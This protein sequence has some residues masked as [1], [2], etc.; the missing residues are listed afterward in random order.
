LDAL[1]PAF[2]AA[3]L[4]GIGDRPARLAA[5]IGTRG[6]F[7]ALIAGFV[8]GHATA[9]GIAVAGAVLIAPR[10]TPEAKSLMLAIALI[11]AGLGALWRRRPIAA[12]DEGSVFVSAATGS[13]LGGDATAFLAFAL[14]ARG[15][16]PVLAGIGALGGAMVLALVAATLARDWE[17][18]PLT[19]ISRIAGIVLCVTGLIVALGGLRLI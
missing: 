7:G 8:L 15:S 14:A 9:I 4:A 13:F 18:L 12:A 16:A 6:R 5:L 1:V 2:V 17:R 3:L 10:L 19:W 11:L